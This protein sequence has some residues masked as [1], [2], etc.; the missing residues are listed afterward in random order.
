MTDS[1]WATL[2]DAEKG[3]LISLWLVAADKGGKIP[4]DPKILRKVCGLDDEPNINKFIELGFVVSE[5]QPNDNQ[6]ATDNQPDDA[7]EESR[8][9][10]SREEEKAKKITNPRDLN[11]TDFE[12]KAK[13]YGKNAKAEL[14]SFI[15]WSLAKGKR[16]K[17]AAAAFR[18]WLKPKAWEQQEQKKEIK[19]V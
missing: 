9:E 6:M 2:T 16:H 13:Q 4:S 3:Q 18:N 8:E 14:E 17:D 12:N 5:C 1:D 11:P 15:D 10:E 7:P 19:Y